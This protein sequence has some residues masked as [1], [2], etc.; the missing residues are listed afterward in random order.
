MITEYT[1]SK[2][3]TIPIKEMASP[4]LIHAIAKLGTKIGEYGVA[5]DES[6]EDMLKALK[7]EAIERLANKETE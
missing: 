7:S 6:D 1:N 5:T 3:E 2:G 4:H